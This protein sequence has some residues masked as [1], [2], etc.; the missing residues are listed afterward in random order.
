M[1]RRARSA[2]LT[3]LEQ[4]R[5]VF[6]LP[7]LYQL[8]AL[9]ERR[10]VGRPAEFPPY[11]LLGYGVLARVFRSG[12]RAEIEL[13]QSGTWSVIVD[14]VE[15]MRRQRPDLEIAAPPRRAPGWDAY[16]YA[17]NRRFT[18]P[19]VLEE[20]CEEFT[21]LA[22]AQAH[23]AGL[24][25]PDGPGSL[26]HP[27]RSRVVYGDGTVV[28]PMYRPPAAKRLKEEDGSTR[29]VYLDAAGQEIDAPRKRYDPD[30]AEHHGHTGPVHGQN[31]VGLYVRGDGPHQRIVLAV[32][33]VPRPGAEADT[34]VE[35][36]KRVHAVAGAG[37]QAAV[38]DGAWRGRHINHVMENCGVVVINKVHSTSRSPGRRRT[39]PAEGNPRWYALGSWE[40]DTDGGPC[41]HTLAAVDGAVSEVGLDAEGA[42]VLLA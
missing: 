31:F 18:V 39:T 12:A 27:A 7:A 21:E 34:A 24:L 14:A 29:T 2:G 40:H 16:R 10:P 37:I 23:E 20:M 22:V 35:L 11:L 36:F 38:Y 5:A 19:E 1:S 8:A 33:R 28:S 41:T 4:V 9:V 6:R 30:S 3:T 15:Q 25:R 13:A 32:D 17:R 42:P 26:C